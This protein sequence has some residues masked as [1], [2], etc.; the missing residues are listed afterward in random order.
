MNIVLKDYEQKDFALTINSIKSPE[1]LL[2]W[3]GPI[4]TYPLTI[5]QLEKYVQPTQG[6]PPSRK[7]FSAVNSEDGIT[8]GQIE[9]NNISYTNLSATLSRVLILDSTVRG[10]GL[11]LQMVNKTLEFGIH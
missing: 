9:L 3:A 2:Q 6:N 7:I 1:F 8:V 10:K 11:G 4:F 5:E